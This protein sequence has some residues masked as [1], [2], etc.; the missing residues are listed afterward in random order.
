ME[1]SHK[2]GLAFFLTELRLEIS[3]MKNEGASSGLCPVLSISATSSAELAV[4]R[5][6]QT[7]YQN[8]ESKL[9]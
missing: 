6:G 1:K 3:S 8:L 7:W 2:S 9:T 4:R 5:T